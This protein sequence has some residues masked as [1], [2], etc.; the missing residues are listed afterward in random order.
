MTLYAPLNLQVAGS[1]A[2]AAPRASRCGPKECAG[3][4]FCARPDASR[5]EADRPTRLHRPVATRRGRRAFTGARKLVVRAAEESSDAAPAAPR[6]EQRQRR[7]PRTVTVQMETITPGQE[8]EGTVVRGARA[9]APAVAAR[10]AVAAPPARR[11]RSPQPPPRPPAPPPRPLGPPGPHAHAR[12]P[13]S[14]LADQGGGL[15]RVCQHRRRERRPRSRVAAVGACG[16]GTAAAP[17]ACGLQRLR[18]QQRQQQLWKDPKQGQQQE[19]AQ[20][21]QRR[22]QRQRAAE[23]AAPDRSSSAPCAVESILEPWHRRNVNN[24]RTAT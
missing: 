16:T 7:A 18:S 13:L 12:T 15:W 8:F 10:A 5:H 1:R 17:P 4:G 22:E 9:G 19:Q 14:P 20:Q 3:W 21:R 23:R 6:Q 24:H 2:G 11:S